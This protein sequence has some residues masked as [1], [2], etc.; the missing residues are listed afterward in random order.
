MSSNP[1]FEIPPF[2]EKLKLPCGCKIETLIDNGE[3]T[4]KIEPCNVYCDNYKYVLE[5]ADKQGKPVEYRMKDEGY[6]RN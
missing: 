6:R 5:E 4:L 3:P 2:S 1:P